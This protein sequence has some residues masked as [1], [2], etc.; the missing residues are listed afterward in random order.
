MATFHD[1]QFPTVIAQGAVAIQ[2]FSTSVAMSSGGREQ[3]N[4][5]WSQPRMR[6]NVGTGLRSR[7]DIATL[8]AFFRARA[9]KLHAFRFKDW[10]DY[11]VAKQQIGT[12]DGSDA[13]W[14]IVKAYASGPT[15]VYRNITR[16]VSG[17]VRCW[18]DGVERT[19]GAGA[20]QFQVDLSTG[21]IT[22]GATLAALL[23]KLIEASCEFDV[24][25]R[26]DSDE[27]ALTQ[28]SHEIGSYADI[29]VVE[30]RE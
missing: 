20:T 26:F 5:N 17:T 25:A 14:Q 27:I 23:S 22:L 8:Q 10:S 30:I 29:P 21:I 6:W 16:P 2:A 4:G 1:D 19:I 24:P 28:R 7:A 11:T 15:T 9:G 18:V 13:T 3:R 12:T